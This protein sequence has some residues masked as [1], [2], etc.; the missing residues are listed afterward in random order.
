MGAASKM[1][2]DGEDDREID[3]DDDE[4]GSCNIELM[5]SAFDSCG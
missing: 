2:T 3:S 1:E 5:H 4:V